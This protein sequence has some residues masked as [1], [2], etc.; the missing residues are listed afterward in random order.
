M[1]NWVACRDFEMLRPRTGYK[2][3]HIVR[4]SCERKVRIPRPLWLLAFECRSFDPRPEKNE[5][6]Y[7]YWSPTWITEF[8]SWKV[9]FRTVIASM[10]AF[11]S[12]LWK[13][14]LNLWRRWFWWLQV[15]SSLFFFFCH[16]IFLND[17]FVFAYFE[18]TT[19]LIIHRILEWLI[20]LGIIDLCNSTLLLR[21]Y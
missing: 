13:F 18:T 4:T 9:K 8:D 11:L 15:F 7:G 5:I 19:C 21:D 10:F 1:D 20:F 17:K 16:R 12:L 2:L 3:R 6:P 14:G